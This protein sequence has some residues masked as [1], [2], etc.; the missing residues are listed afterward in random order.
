MDARVDDNALI[1]EHDLSSS[2]RKA[3]YLVMPWT[4]LLNILCLS[5]P[6]ETIPVF[7]TKPMLEPHKVKND[8]LNTTASSL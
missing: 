5:F 7:P 4:V 2:V 3:V 8:H 6:V 1:N